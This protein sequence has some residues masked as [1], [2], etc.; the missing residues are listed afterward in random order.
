MAELAAA[1]AL[2]LAAPVAA[3]ACPM[4][5]SQAASAGQ[6]RIQA[7]RSGITVLTIPPLA[8]ALGLTLVTYRKRNQFSEEEGPLPPHRQ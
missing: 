1:T 3:H 5:Y 2:A 8:I 6:H 7:L 4:C